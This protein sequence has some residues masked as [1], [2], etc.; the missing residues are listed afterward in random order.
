MLDAG[1][2]PRAIVLLYYLLTAFFGVLALILPSGVY[3]LV[4]LALIGA[5]AVF[6]LV[7]SK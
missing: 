2:K 6:V 4:A 7:K 3:K 1:L 5:G